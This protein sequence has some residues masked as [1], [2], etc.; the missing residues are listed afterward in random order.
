MQM[1]SR[2]KRALVPSEITQQT[3]PEVAL[4]LL[5]RARQWSVPIQTMVVD[6]SYRDNPHFLTGVR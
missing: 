4:G 6:A 5:G 3:K 1:T 2:R